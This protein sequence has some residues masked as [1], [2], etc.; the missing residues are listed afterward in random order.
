M[1]D[2]LKQGQ[3]NAGCDAKGEGVEDGREE[4]DEHEEEL[5]EGADADE[6]IDVVGGFFDQGVGY[7]CDHGGENCFLSAALVVF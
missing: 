4:D 3:S 1:A 7:Y 5:G 6:E 2:D